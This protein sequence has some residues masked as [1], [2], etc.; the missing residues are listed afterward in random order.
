DKPHKPHDKPHKPHDKPHKPHGII[1]SP[2]DVGD[3]HPTCTRGVLTW[4]GRHVLPTRATHVRSLAVLVLPSYLQYRCTQAYLHLQEGRQQKWRQLWPLL[5]LVASITNICYYL[6]YIGGDSAVC[7]L[8]H[9]VSGVTLTRRSP[10]DERDQHALTWRQQL[11]AATPVKLMEFLELAAFLLQFLETWYSSDRSSGASMAPQHESR[12]P[13]FPH[14]APAG[15][16][17]PRCPVCHG[18]IKQPTALAVSGLVF[19]Y[20]CVLPHVRR[21]RTCPVTGYPASTR[22]LVRVYHV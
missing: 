16:P 10:Q 18:E 3:S 14:E 22:Q 17:D 19:C 13:P 2:N 12:V 7:S 15:G 4:L 11:V 20:A 21:W 6:R 5:Q 1:P 9:A 8:S